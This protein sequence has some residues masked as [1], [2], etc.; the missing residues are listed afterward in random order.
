MVRDK[1]PGRL[2]RHPYT[3]RGAVRFLHIPGES[4]LT[5]PRQRSVL[6]AA[7]SSAVGFDSNS[8]IHS[9][10]DTLLAAQIA[11][12]GLNETWPRRKNCSLSAKFASRYMSVVAVSACRARD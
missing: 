6:V 1:P 12:G 2:R 3:R 5:L 10:L 11:L 4:S 9:G 8:V 7:V